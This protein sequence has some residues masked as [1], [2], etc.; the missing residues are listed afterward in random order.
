MPLESLRL[1]IELVLAFFVWI[2]VGLRWLH[3]ILLAYHL[4]RCA[5]VLLTLLRRLRVQST[6]WLHSINTSLVAHH[7]VVP[8]LVRG[9]G[10]IGARLIHTAIRHNSLNLHHWIELLAGLLKLLFGC[11]VV[12]IWAHSTHGISS[13]LLSN[14]VAEA[15]SDAGLVLYLDVDWII[16]V[17][18]V[19]IWHWTLRAWS[20][21]HAA[22]AGHSAH[23]AS[24]L[25]NL[26]TTA[27][28]SIHGVVHHSSFI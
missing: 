22:L 11:R 27:T 21:L 28:T 8:F 6:F 19:A 1:I 14:N 20:S 3:L 10:R 2:H 24:W 7:S 9:Y 25:E 26:L 12:R 18:L 15:A 16:L 13:S 23:L 5:G 17:D 4:L